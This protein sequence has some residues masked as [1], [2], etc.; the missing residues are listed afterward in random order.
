MTALRRR[1][2]E[3]LQRR[4]FAPTTQPCDVAAVQQLARHYGRAPDQLG[5]AERR[6]YF[7]F[8]LN[9]QTVAESPC[10]MHL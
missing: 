6:Q 8:L 7:L 4:G 9:E 1:L 3:D 10:R 2:L 5:E